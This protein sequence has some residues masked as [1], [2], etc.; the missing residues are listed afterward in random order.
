MGIIKKQTLFD[1]WISFAEVD[2]WNQ[3]LKIKNT[4]I[5]LLKVIKSN[6]KIFL[7]NK[8]KSGTPK[9][10]RTIKIKAVTERK[11][12]KVIKAKGTIK[13]VT[14]RKVIKVIKAK[15]TIKAVKERKIIKIKTVKI[16]AKKK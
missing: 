7:I 16:W 15:G 4:Q 8:T 5:N 14:E 2:F 13:A 10:K 6:L 1:A 9:N 3:W 12:I 11:V